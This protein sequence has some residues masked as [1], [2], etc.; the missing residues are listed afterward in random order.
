MRKTRR[1]LNRCNTLLHV[2]VD[3]G[4][5]RRGPIGVFLHKGTKSFTEITSR[6]AAEID[7]KMPA[8]LRRRF[9]PMQAQA[10][11]LPAQIAPSLCT[12]GPASRGFDSRDASVVKVIL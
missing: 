12:S 7:A 5:G 2:T 10:T 1:I 11:R 4:R 3:L 8:N 9:T 6:E